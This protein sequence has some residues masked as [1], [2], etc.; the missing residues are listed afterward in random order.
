MRVAWFSPLPP[1][2]SGIAAYSAE[3][4]PRLRARGHEIEPFTD[5]NAH[6]FVWQHRRRPYALTVYQLGNAAAH[7]YMWAYLFRYRG[8]V[9][10]HD[11]Q[12]HQARALFLTK[13]WQPRTADYVAEVRANHPDAPADLPYLVLARMGERMYQHWPMVRLVI[14]SAKMTVVHNG[15]VADDLRHLYPG[16]SI[17]AIEMGI[18]ARSS[19]PEPPDAT[20]IRSQHSIPAQAFVVAALGGVTAEKRIP[21][22]IRAVAAIADRHPH[23]HLMLVGDPAAHYDAIEDARASGIAERVHVTGYVP[24]A[25]LPRYLA[26]ADLCACLRWPTNRETSASWLRCLAAARPTLITELA[27]LGHVP[28]L[29]PRGWRLLNITAP[30]HDAVAV[31]IDLLDEEHSLQLALERLVIDAP[32]RSRLSRAAHA[33]WHQHHRL[34]PMVDAYERLLADAVLLPVPSVELP[35]HLVAD[36]AAQLQ[37]LARDFGIADPLPGGTPRDRAQS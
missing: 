18:D 3:L 9:V 28:T 37:A 5:A 16:A 15:W 14:R 11:V 27:H 30:P 21:Q 31:S 1:S 22:I 10:L 24:D 35:P 13:R 26:A 34:E 6:E 8:V 4:V 33:W 7:D 36:G 25:D 20:G 17:R 2:T 19:G 32:L 29:D 23:L 12:L